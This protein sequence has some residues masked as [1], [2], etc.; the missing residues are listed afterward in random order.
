MTEKRDYYEVLGV[1]RNASQQEIKSAYRRL[2]KK[3]HPDLHPDDPDAREKFKEVSEA[4]SVLSDPEK[5]QRYD[6]FGFAGVSDQG[7]FEGAGFSMED[8]LS[9]I[10]GFGD[11]FGG[12]RRRS[13]RPRQVRGE[14]VED[15]IRLTFEEAAFG[16]EKEVAIRRV[17]PCGE[18]GGKGGTGVERCPRCGG[19][20]EIRQVRNLGFSQFIN[21][22]TCPQCRG[23]G[24]FVK[25]VCKKCKGKRIEIDTKK[26]KVNVPP[27]VE[28]GMHFKIEG[29]GHLPSRDA[30]PGDAFLQVVVEP[31]PLF[32]R[33]GA[34]V[35][36]ELH[37]DLATAI[38]GGEVSLPVV[39]GQVKLKIPPG[40]Q[41]HTEFRLRGKGIP[42]FKRG[43]RGDHYVKVVVDVPLDLTD[44]QVAL[45]KRFQEIEEEKS[46]AA[47]EKAEKER[48][49][50]AGGPQ[51]SNNMMPKRFGKTRRK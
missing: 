25:R 49:E 43:G 51:P 41:S 35:Y 19:S 23:T 31:H 4:F 14:D 21:V 12:G 22:T 38:L 42:K 11:I 33:D 24:E 46:A 15:R 13:K 37:V 20:G 6:R 17:V 32:K 36:G 45:I 50:E 5:R 10:F 26:I 7:G 27:G 1:D 40:T 44:E 30:I 3:Y 47:R 16:V 29:A 18:C 48:R 8:I 2:V 9:Q 28:S 39:D 34:D